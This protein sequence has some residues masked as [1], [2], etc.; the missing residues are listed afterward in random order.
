MFVATLKTKKWKQPKH[1]S[2]DVWIH[3]TVQSYN[4]IYYYAIKRNEILT[5][6]CE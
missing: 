6:Q 2:I 5:L 3:K 4:E 1:Q